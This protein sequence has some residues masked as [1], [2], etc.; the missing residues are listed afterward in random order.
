MMGSVKTQRFAFCLAAALAASALTAGAQTLET[1]ALRALYLASKS[2]PDS[3]VAEISG[4]RGG[5]QPQSWTIYFKDPAARGGVRE[6][7]VTRGDVESVRTPLRG[8]SEVAGLPTI[9][10]GKVNYDSDRAFQIANSQAV[11]AKVGFNWIDYRLRAN[12]SGVPVWSVT[13]IDSMGVKAGD[14]EISAESG[15][16]LRSLSGAVP[17]TPATT[18]GQPQVGGLIGDLRD[19]GKDLGKGV[20][21]AVVNTVGNAQEILTGERTIGNEQKPSNNTPDD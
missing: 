20:S 4:Q 19:L 9:D 1:T 15:E 5:T 7:V 17:V 18:G 13:L 21:D 2:A 8:F 11:A 10:R 3:P 12:A 16:I 14:L 6:V